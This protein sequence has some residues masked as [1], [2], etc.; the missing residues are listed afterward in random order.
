VRFLQVLLSIT[1]LVVTPVV[2]MVFA[3]SYGTGEPL[4]DAATH[5]V[6]DLQDL[7]GSRKA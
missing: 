6:Q 1:V 7:L 2:A 5:L 3:Y 4:R